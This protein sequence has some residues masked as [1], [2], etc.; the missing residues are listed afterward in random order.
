MGTE[1]FVAVRFWERR[2]RN[3]EGRLAEALVH[4]YC[5]SES[6]RL[7]AY[8]AAKTA[9]VSTSFA[10]RVLWRW[11]GDGW[12]VDE[13]AGP[14]PQRRFYRPTESGLREFGARYGK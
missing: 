1:V 13:W 14:P 9:K 3:A 11:L 2:R 7:S 12:L 10:Y 5:C 8:D 6:R 4:A